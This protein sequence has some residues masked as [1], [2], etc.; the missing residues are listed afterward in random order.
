MQIQFDPALSTSS[1]FE[2]PHPRPK[3][4]NTFTKEEDELLLLLASDYKERNWKIISSFFE[5]K[6]YIQCFSRYKRIRPGVKKGPWT[7]EEDRKILN[8]MKKFGNSWAKIANSMKSRNGKQIRDRYINVLNPDINKSPFS[9]TE[10]E[11]IIK[12]REIL[13]SKWARIAKECGTGRSPDMIKNRYYSH[14]KNKT[15]KLISSTGQNDLI[16]EG[17]LFLSNEVDA[18]KNNVDNND[19]VS[20]SNFSIINIDEEK[21]DTHEE[22]GIDKQDV[23]LAKVFKL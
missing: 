8:G 13:G 23:L 14:L 19:N 22:I 9:Q 16:D 4:K 17:G 10:D 1:T 11:N 18:S 5:N 15:A 7:P 6:S 21:K 2:S 12:Y 20:N 3:P